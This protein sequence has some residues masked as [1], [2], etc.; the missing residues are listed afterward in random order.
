[1][2]GHTQMLTGT[3]TMRIPALHSVRLGGEFPEALAA[4]LAYAR[5]AETAVVTVPNTVRIAP[6][7]AKAAGLRAT[8]SV[9][10][11]YICPND[12]GPPPAVRATEFEIV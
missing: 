12:S 5:T 6:A 3:G 9:F 2:Q 8:G 1:M 11:A 7:V 10:G 4:L